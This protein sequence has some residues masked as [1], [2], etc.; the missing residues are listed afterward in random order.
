MVTPEIPTGLLT[1]VGTIFSGLVI[2]TLWVWRHTTSL[3]GEDEERIRELENNQESSYK[4][5]LAE[6]YIEIESLIEEDD[7]PAEM[8][9]DERVVNAIE[10][11]VNEEDL[12]SIVEKLDEM[13]TAEDLWDNHR[14]DYKGAYKKFGTSAILVFILSLVI[15]GWSITQEHTFSTSSGVVYLV[16]GFFSLNYGWDGIGYFNDARE[17]K[18]EFEERW[19]EYKRIE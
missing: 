13:G 18:E 2:L 1:F 14:E 16:L 10:Q 8:T 17:H 7:Y 11:E 9:Q 4:A 6:L 19:R 5:E 3:D 12:G 15:L